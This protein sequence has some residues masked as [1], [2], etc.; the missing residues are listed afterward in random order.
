MSGR[1]FRTRTMSDLVRELRQSAARFESEVNSIV[2]REGGRG[3]R[4]IKRVWP[5]VGKTGWLRPTGRSIRGWTFEKVGKLEWRHAN[6][7]D[8]APHVHPPGNPVTLDESVVPD[9]LG[10]FRARTE[11]GLR[12]L[13]K[14]S[15]TGASPTR[16][17]GGRLRL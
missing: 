1:S 9:I 8:Y 10:K 17:L 13:L 3:L 12:D 5:D 2:E 15:L 6:S 4:E 14:R 7:V 11:D 16:G